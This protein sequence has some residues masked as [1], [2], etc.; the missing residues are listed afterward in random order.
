MALLVLD[1]LLGEPESARAP[2]DLP[3][4]RRP[5]RQVEYEL[6]SPTRSNEQTQLNASLSS[7][8][9]DICLI[10]QKVIEIRLKEFRCE[11]TFNG[12]V[13]L[14]RSGNQN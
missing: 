5:F 12:K 1:K 7:F 8:L 2:E 6:G 3:F 4:R 13:G 9:D 11:R 14:P 10:Y